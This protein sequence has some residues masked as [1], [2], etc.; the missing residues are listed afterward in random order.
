MKKEFSLGWKRSKQRRKQRKYLANAP[1][2]IRRKL[3]SSNLSKELRKKYGRRSFPL[4]KNDVVKIMRGKFAGKTGKVNEVDLKRLRVSIEG[5]QNQKKEGTKV[6]VFF[7]AS[8]LQIIELN[9]EDKKRQEQLK[10]GKGE[11][12]ASEK[13]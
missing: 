9:L 7:H 1:L 8:K 5:I 6:N 4:R 2:H 12:N 13:K 3:M 11:E 10:A